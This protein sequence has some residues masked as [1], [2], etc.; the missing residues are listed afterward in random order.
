MAR[1]KKAA[2]PLHRR[3]QLMR[4][5]LRF[6]EML[7]GSFICRQIRCGRPRCRCAQKGQGHP[8]YQITVRIEGQTQTY[9]IPARW[10]SYIRQRVGFHKQ[11]EQR[12][13]EILKI[14]LKRWLAQKQKEP[15]SGVSPV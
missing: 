13:E 9:M 3:S 10:V 4:Q 12:V 7:P 2:D 14:N 6:R 15:S 5:L 1:L 11:F 8:A